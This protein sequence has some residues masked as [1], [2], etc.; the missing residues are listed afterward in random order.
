MAQPDVLSD[1][2]HGVDVLD[3]V[4]E[5]KNE[6]IA[7]MAAMI[8]MI[9]FVFVK[10]QLPKLQAPWLN[11]EAFQPLPLAEIRTITHN[12]KFFRFAL[13]G[14]T[15]RLGLP[16][17]QHITFYG[18]DE[19]GKDVYR[20]YTPVSSDSQL[21]YVDFV[22]KLYPQGKMS[23]ILS[24]MQVGDSM[25]MKGPKGRFT[26]QPNMKRAIGEQRLLCQPGAYVPSAHQRI[27]TVC[28]C[29]QATFGGQQRDQLHRSACPPSHETST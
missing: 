10:Y 6:L 26:Y 27:Q 18:Q 11:P 9:A 22:I 3:K 17:G 15:V 8:A 1:A 19:E 21:G 7:V 2:L 28:C 5:H 24:K 20:S 23:Q 29:H 25:L 14:K 16:V 12:T 13:P 4:L